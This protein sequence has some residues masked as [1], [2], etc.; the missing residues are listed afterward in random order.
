MCKTLH[1]SRSKHLL[2]SRYKYSSRHFILPVIL[3]SIVY[4]VPK[5]WEL[6]TLCLPPSV[7]MTNQTQK[8]SALGNSTISNSTLFNSTV[9]HFTTSNST[10]PCSYW[11]LVLVASDFRY[12]DLNGL[13]KLSEYQG[14]YINKVHLYF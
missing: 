4:N 12:I 8:N 6:E 7:V 3:Y 1:M 9:S 5:F 13:T 14:I 10:I 2:A 11:E